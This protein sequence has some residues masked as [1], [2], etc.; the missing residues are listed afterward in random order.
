[1][2]LIGVSAGML[3]VAAVKQDTRWGGAAVLLFLAQCVWSFAQ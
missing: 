1:M 3:L 2:L